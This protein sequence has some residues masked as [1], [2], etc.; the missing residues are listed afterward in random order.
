MRR[1]KQNTR[2]FG[3]IVM[4][5]AGGRV[6]YNDAKSEGVLFMISHYRLRSALRANLLL[7]LFI[8]RTFIL[9]LKYSRKLK[10]I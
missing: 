5:E 2:G 7:N 3:V 1:H 4:N 6:H 8:P 9:L 10:I